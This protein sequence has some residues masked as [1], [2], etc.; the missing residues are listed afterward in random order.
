MLLLTTLFS[1][2]VEEPDV[3]PALNTLRRVWSPVFSEAD[4]LPLICEL[5]S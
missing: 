4:E 2:A 1:E 3:T 5:E